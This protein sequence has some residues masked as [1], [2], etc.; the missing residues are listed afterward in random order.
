VERAAEYCEKHNLKLDDTITLQDLATSAYQSKNATEGNLGLFLLALSEGLVERGSVLVVESLDRL[1]RAQVMTALRLLSSILEAGVKVVT[2]ADGYEYTFESVNRNPFDLMYSIMVM[3]RSHDES[4]SKSIRVRAAKVKRRERIISGELKS[5]PGYRPRWIDRVKGVFVLNPVR[6]ASIKRIVQMAIDGMGIDSICR[7]INAEHV[8]TL[9]GGK[10]WGASSIQ[11][12]FNARTLIGEYQPMTVSVTGERTTVGEPVLNYYPAL[13]TRDTWDK[14]QAAVNSRRGL[15]KGRQGETVANLFGDLL[16]SGQD[17]SRMWL[18][19]HRDK[20]KL[21]S[22]HASR[23][24]EGW[25]AFPYEVF[26]TVFL[27]WLRNQKIK[28]SDNST[29]RLSLLRAQLTDVT[30]KL[31]KLKAKTM[32]A[33]GESF[34]TLVEMMTELEGKRKIYTKEV[35]LLSRQTGGKKDLGELIDTMGSMSA[36]ERANVR[37]RLRL[38]IAKLV[39]KIDLYVYGNNNASRAAVAQV[40][41]KDGLDRHFCI[42]TFKGREPQVFSLGMNHMKLDRAFFKGVGDSLLASARDGTFAKGCGILP[43]GKVVSM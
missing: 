40:V 31:A 2:L 22:E 25:C 27:S 38:T 3:S 4:L 35:D 23:T 36:D 14:L 26:E 37:Q 43:G 32:A 21:V 8:P 5:A 29:D 24:G 28:G 42:S 10:K 13:I 18:E 30:S 16:H 6:A 15:Y 17:G 11:H 7:T 12:L 41:L 1:S 33:D 9:G 39:T 34:D 20:R 19:H